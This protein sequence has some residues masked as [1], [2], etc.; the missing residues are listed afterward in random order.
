M[1]KEDVY[2]LINVPLEGMCLV[3]MMLHTAGV[4]EPGNYPE[5]VEIGLLVGVV[6]LNLCYAFLKRGWK[7][8]LK[9]C[10]YQL[11][12]IAVFYFILHGNIPELVCFYGYLAYFCTK[13]RFISFERILSELED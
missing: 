10:L 8:F 2:A 11:P 12:V 3:S 13:I 7:I 5:G 9:N 4:I 1:E 6:V